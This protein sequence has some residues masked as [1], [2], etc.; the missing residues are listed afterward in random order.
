MAGGGPSGGSKVTLENQGNQ[1]YGFALTMMIVLFF[2]IGFITVLNDVLIP[3]MKEIF[4]FKEDENWK[5]M[6]IQFAFFIAYGVMSIPAG[7]IINKFGYKKGLILALGVIAAGL[8]LFV[9]ASLVESYVFFLVALFIVGNGLAILQV[10]INPYIVALGPE[11][12][13]ASRLNFGG[14][15][16]STATAVGPIL[17]AWLILDECV[18]PQE[19]IGLVRGPYIALAI[20]IIVIA[21]VLSASKLP[22]LRTEAATGTKVSGS[23]W[24]FMHLRLG[25][26]AIFFYVGAEV[27]I[28][29]LLVIYLKT[30]AMGSIPENLASSLVAYYWSSA[31]IGRFIGSA[32][33]KRI[34]A[35]KALSFVAV[36]ALLLIGLSMFG[37][38]LEAKMSIPVIAMGNDCDTG[39]FNLGFTP[40][41]VPVAAFCLVLV[42]LMN[43]IMWPSIFPLGIAKLGEHTSQGSGFMVTMV[44]GGAFI[45]LLQGAL[46]DSIG[47]RYSFIICAVC[48]VYILFFAI[49]G[50]KM[51]KIATMKDDEVA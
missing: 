29:S 1:S 35:N 19:K 18:S 31:M 33:T 26:G 8:L 40:V 24:D 27:A 25:A 3:S 28:G 46:A 21:A 7:M 41:T 14:A 36:A 2:M 20:I 10:A 16:N 32:V 45:P 17:G 49:K 6:L 9:P 12:T 34:Q 37:P 13:G 15:L 23:A 4:N 50:Y 5:L 39:A 43:S 30:E 48:Y 22:K 42:G 51:G 11:E 44:V 47:F 38:L